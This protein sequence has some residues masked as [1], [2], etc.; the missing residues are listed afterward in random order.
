MASTFIRVAERAE[1][2]HKEKP[3]SG[4]STKDEAELETKWQ[5]A[6]MREG[7]RNQELP[8]K[9]QWYYTMARGHVPGVYTDWGKVEHQVNGFSGT[10]HKKLQDHK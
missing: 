8:P 4:P 9:M 2:C 3:G 1:K 10:V 5:A 7:S 6:K